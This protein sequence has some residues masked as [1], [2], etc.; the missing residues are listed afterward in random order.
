MKHVQETL[1]DGLK[2][3]LSH[4]ERVSNQKRLFFRKKKKLCQEVQDQIDP[5]LSTFYDVYSMASY[6]TKPFV[7]PIADVPDKIPF[8]VETSYISEGEE[9]N[10][11][12]EIL[13]HPDKQITFYMWKE[14]ENSYTSLSMRYKVYY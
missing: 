8:R 2:K 13:N 1:E 11:K 14:F 4:G 6:H 3:I 9:D 12:V 10:V 7:D 5:Y